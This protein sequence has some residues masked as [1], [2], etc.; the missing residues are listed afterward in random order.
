EGG[1]YTDKSRQLQGASPYLINLDMNYSPKF[2]G[3]R[4]L[5]LSA[6]YNI[7]GP[8]IS[9]V[10]INGISN[11]IEEA[12]H[13]LDFVAVY[14]LNPKMKIKLQGKN[15]IN[16][17]QKFTQKIKDTGRKETVEHYKKGTGF[18]IGFSMNF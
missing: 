5:S 2:T 11:V 4:E 17:D 14:S 15:L 18:S 12:F 1:L 13:L 3:E 8:R 16:Q 6:V 10:G 9:A 7:Q